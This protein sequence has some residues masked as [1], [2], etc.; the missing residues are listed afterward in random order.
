MWFYDIVCTYGRSWSIVFAIFGFIRYIL[1]LL[2]IHVIGT[3][4]VFRP[5]LQADLGPN[6]F[7]SL[8]FDWVLGILTEI[9]FEAVLWYGPNKT[10]PYSKQRFNHT[11]YDIHGRSED[12]ILVCIQ[13]LRHSVFFFVACKTY[14]K[15]DRS[16]FWRHTCQSRRKVRSQ[17]SCPTTQLGT[18]V[19]DATIV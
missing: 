14:I 12:I 3:V 17:H 8:N 4:C 11:P 19:L 2:Y 13:K 18:M 10:K 5:K 7:I 15:Q 9:T 16:K 1:F 6:R